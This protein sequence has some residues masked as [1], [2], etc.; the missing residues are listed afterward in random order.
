MLYKNVLLCTIDHCEFKVCFFLKSVTFKLHY[1][2]V[3][4][5]IKNTRKIA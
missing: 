1:L 3:G 5:V 2:S 4:I